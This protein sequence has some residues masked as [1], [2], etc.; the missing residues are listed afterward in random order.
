M[1]HDTT[2]GC[3][4][5]PRRSGLEPVAGHRWPRRSPTSRTT[6][7]SAAMAIALASNGRGTVGRRRSR[8]RPA[9]RSSV[10]ALDSS[11]AATV[12]AVAADRPSGEEDLGD[13]VE[14]RHV[15]GAGLADGELQRGGD[16][17]GAAGARPSG[18]SRRRGRGRWRRRRSGSTAPGRTPSAC[19]RA[20]RGRASRPASRTRCAAR[21]RGRSRRRCRRGGR[22]RTCRRPSR[23]PRACPA[24][25]RRP[26]RRRRSR[27]SARARGAG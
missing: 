14:Q 12:D 22:G 9:G 15:D 18:P 25:A 21:S 26:R 10:A 8:G 19:R 1:M 24:P 7:C 6:S 23:R 13:V 16:D 17:V 5:G 27:R 3:A 11:T 20:A 4:T 2:P